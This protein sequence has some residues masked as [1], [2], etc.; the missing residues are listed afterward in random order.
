MKDLIFAERDR[1]R[2]VFFSTHILSDVEAMC[3]RVAILREGRVVVSGAMRKLLRGEV[4]RT[5]VTLAHASPELTEELKGKGL[6]VSARTDVIV[7]EV[8]GEA[9]VG[10]VL[11]AALDRG[12]QVVEVVPR[13]ETLEELFLRQA[14]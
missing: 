7:V 4:L 2:T 5:D 8:E 14:L 1:G 6:S 3:D 12:A 10:E 11:K 13:R 9:R